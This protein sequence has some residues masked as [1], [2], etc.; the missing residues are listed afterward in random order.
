MTTTARLLRRFLGS[1]LLFLLLGCLPSVQALAAPAPPPTAV[2]G[3]IS[4]LDGKVRLPGVVVTLTT[5]TGQPAGET[6][7]DADGHYR[8][9]VPKPG[10]YKLTTSIEGFHKGEQPVQLAEGVTRTVDMDLK[11][12]EIEQTV[13]V[14]PTSDTPMNL[15]NPLAPV[16]SITG[17]EIS[18]SAMS[19]GSVAAELRWLPSVS[20]YGREW[21]IKGGRPNQ[22][23]LQI[24]GAQVLDPAAGISPVQLPGDA[25]NS[26]Q[27][28]ANPYAVEFGN[29][30]TGM[31]AVSTRSGGNK[32]SAT[33][34]DFFPAFILKRGSSNPFHIVALG[35]ESPRVAVGGPVIANKLFVA[36]SFQVRYE[37][38]DVASRPQDERKTTKNL[39][40]F[41]RLDYVVSQRNTLTG[42]FTLAPENANW[43]N[44]DTFNPPDA[45]ADI[46]QRVYRAGVR[47]TTQLPHAMVLDTLAHF[48][49]YGTSVDGHGTGTEMLL[50][51][52]QNGGIYYAKQS[53]NAEALEASAV[54]SAFVAD[55]S[56]DHLVKF[57]A[58]VLYATFDGQLQTRP[59]DIMRE[60]GT[61]T[62][63]LVSGPVVGGQSATEA[64]LFVQDRWHV[65]SSL[66]VEYGVR[67]ERDGV[68]GRV[69]VIPR[70]GAALA[71]DKNRNAMI[72][73]GWGLF[74]ERT[75]LMAGA[76]GRL[77]DLTE[78]AYGPDGTTVLGT[79]VVYSH[80]LAPSPQTPRSS[81]WNIGY[82]HRIA[83]W[84]SVRAN[85]LERR[86]SHELALDTSSTGG[87]G[88]ISLD[89]NG[90]SVYRDTE[91]GAHFRRGTV[92]DLDVSY[93]RSSSRAE[94]NDIYGYF[95]NL[96]ANPIVRADAYGPTDT[97]APNRFVGRARITLPHRWILEA[98]GEVRDGYPWSAVDEQLDFVGTRNGLRFPVMK[99]L[100]ASIEHQFRIGRFRPWLGF[101]V[102]NAFDSFQPG[103]VQ[104]NIASPNFGAF[105][106]S[107]VRQVR[108]TVHFHP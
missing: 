80:V 73:G 17:R 61:M 25:V 104:R 11:L 40:S 53:R 22:I 18:E 19:S 56:G 86:G 90:T 70:F 43:F 84:V 44:L 66:L 83:K 99:T 50:A 4:T 108:F 57:G 85:H 7:S 89:S 79:P 42:T 72:R 5:S 46:R 14:T 47:D 37:S 62:R 20:A 102:I 30:S 96:T 97:D 24:E 81:T 1:G 103:D 29:F 93:T 3:T 82:E 76:F 41:T 36:E 78:T 9:E 94:L 105:Y 100:D 68:F 64:S 52:E 55:K 13:N 8:I 15:A 45:T 59:I 10:V 67:V 48:T 38:S 71:L 69:N 33:V 32:W 95:L 65:R 2:T 23:G 27:V 91:L 87:T 39:V 28:M 106:S 34:N 49:H 26:I 74:Y 77:S 63:R 21:A 54:V 51:P 101:V 31:I 60:D 16:E 75:P 92:L 12:L 6:V 107:P 58:D 35:S 98:A 88:V